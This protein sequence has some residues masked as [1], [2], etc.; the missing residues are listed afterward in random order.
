MKILVIHNYYQQSGGEDVVVAQETALLRKAGH[1][2]IPYYR[3]NA[4]VDSFGWRIASG[5]QRV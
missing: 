1:E 3:S 4:E 2:V 5:R